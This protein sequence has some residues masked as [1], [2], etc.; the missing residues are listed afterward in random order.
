MKD[1]EKFTAGSDIRMLTNFE[2]KAAVGAT[3]RGEQVLAVMELTFQPEQNL[4]GSVRVGVTPESLLRL[5]NYLLQ[6]ATSLQ[7]TTTP[8]P[9]A[10]H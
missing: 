3:P 8:P 10:R 1:G 7:K 4:P 2:V 6:Q 5:A 9:G